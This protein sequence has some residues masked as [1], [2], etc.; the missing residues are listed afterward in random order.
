MKTYHWTGV[1]NNEPQHGQLQAENIHYARAMLRQQ[2]I[3]ISSIKKKYN[4]FN[5]KTTGKNQIY[6]LQ[7]LSSL[8]KSGISLFEAITLIGRSNNHP[9]IKHHCTLLIEKLR[10]GTSLHKACQAMLNNSTCQ[11]IAIGEQ[12]GELEKMLDYAIK[13][14]E[15]QQALIQ[16]TKSALFY[17]SIVVVFAI[18]ITLVLLKFV[19]PQF[20]SLFIEQDI[21]LPLPTKFVI[22]ISNYCQHLFLPSLIT[23]LPLTLLI[24]FNRIFSKKITNV[25]FSIINKLPLF[26]KIILTAELANLSNCLAINLEAGI[27]ILTALTSASEAIK[28][29]SLK[30]QLQKSQQQLE[31]GQNLTNS[32][33]QIPLLPTIFIELIEHGEKSGRLTTMLKQLNKHFQTTL[34][35]Y[36]SRCHILLEPII[37]LVLGI[38]IGGLMLSMYLPMFQM[39]KVL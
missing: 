7:Q 34:A 14:K 3:S 38:T 32:L 21:P 17:P 33:R 31:S 18:S 39:G 25:I 13:I 9:K 15:S 1:K 12:T 30:K 5:N 8:L 10:G 23:I 11:L 28:L 37:M 24:T 35:A 20:A 4:F 27:P 26:K 6:F 2:H 22:S 19:I 29:K 16:Q 36:L